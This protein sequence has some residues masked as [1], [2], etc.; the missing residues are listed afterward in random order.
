M[1]TE[2]ITIATDAGHELTGSLELPTGL[3]SGAS[4][5]AHCFPCTT[6]SRAAVSAGSY[7]PMTMPTI[8][9]A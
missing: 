9:A 5:F 3:V 1:P 2:K 7:T 6:P 8:S 4:L